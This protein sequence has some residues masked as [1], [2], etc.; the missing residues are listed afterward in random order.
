MMSSVDL[1]YF[2]KNGYSLVTLVILED[3]YKYQT[4]IS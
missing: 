3:I 2:K 4:L 1:F